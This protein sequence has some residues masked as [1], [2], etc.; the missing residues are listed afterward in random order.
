VAK[1]NSKHKKSTQQ[2]ERQNKAFVLIAVHIALACTATWIFV[3]FL[4]WNPLN[5]FF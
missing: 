1:I 3:A 2:A 5:I 4:N